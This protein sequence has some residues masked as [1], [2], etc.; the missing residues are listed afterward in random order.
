MFECIYDVEGDIDP[1]FGICV[2]KVHEVVG[3]H[4]NL[5]NQPWANGII[6]QTIQQVQEPRTE[7]VVR[8]YEV[9]IW[10][11]PEVLGFI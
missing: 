5:F 8:K 1:E 10:E 9:L 3:Y 4:H 11:D 2:A 6:Y 7:H